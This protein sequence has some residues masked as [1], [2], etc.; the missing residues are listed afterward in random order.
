[1]ENQKELHIPV[2]SVWKN[3]TILKNIFL[4]NSPP[5]IPNETQ[6][7]K[8]E[9]C[10]TQQDFEETLVVGRHP[11]CH[12][13]V[14]HPSISRFHLRIHSKPTSKHLS[15]TDLSSVHGTW[16]S[17]KKIK[18]NVRT[19]MNE[20][21]TLRI[22][23]SSR[24]YKLH[25]IPLSQA[26]D[27]SNPFVPPLDLAAAQEDKEEEII[28]DESPLE[29]QNKE[30]QAVDSTSKDIEFS[31]VCD[32]DELAKV[33]VPH[34][35]EEN[36]IALDE[37][38]QVAQEEMPPDPPT[39]KVNFENVNESLQSQDSMLEGL[40]P[41]FLGENWE[42]IGQ[43]GNYIACPTEEGYPAEVKHEYRDYTGSV[44]EGLDSSFL[45]EN[46]ELLIHD[47]I[48]L[49]PSVIE[50]LAVHMATDLQNAIAGE[51]GGGVVSGMIQN[52]GGRHVDTV[53]EGLDTL[54]LDENLEVLVQKGTPLAPSMI[55]DM[56]VQMETNLN[57]TTIEASIPLVPSVV[58]DL[59]VHTATD[60]HNAM[61]GERECGVVSGMI[62]NDG[63]RH[64]D[65]LSLDILFPDEN[66]EL[67]VQKGTPLATSMIEDMPVKMEPNF[68][69]TTIEEIQSGIE[70][71]TIPNE[72]QI[73]QEK[74]DIQDDV[75]NFWCG[76][77]IPPASLTTE[78]VVLS[79]ENIH[80][81]NEHQ[82][83][84][85]ES[86]PCIP[87]ERKGLENVNV[88]QDSSIKDTNGTKL[89]SFWS[90]NMGVES[91]V[92]SSLSD[93]E[94]LSESEY[95]KSSR[96]SDQSPPLSSIKSAFGSPLIESDQKSASC[97]WLR[98]GKL[99]SAPQILTSRS[100]GKKTRSEQRKVKHEPLCKALFQETDA[101]KDEEEIYTPDKENFT[102]NARRSMKKRTMLRE[103]K[104]SNAG[105]SFFS[106][107]I[108]NSKVDYEDSLSPSS[109]KENNSPGTFLQ[110]E[111]TLH[112][113]VNKPK[114]IQ[115]RER[116][117]ER[118]PFQSLLADSPQRNTSETC[119]PD[120]ILN[121]DKCS[122]Q[123]I[124]EWR[125]LVDTTTLLNKKSRKAL[126]LLEGL[127]G[128][129]LIIPRIVINDLACLKRQTSFFRRNTEVSSALDW[130]E[131][132]MA[133]S[134]WWIHVQ[135]SSEE[136]GPVAPTPPASPCS[137]VSSSS[138]FSNFV[139][140]PELLSPAVEDHVIDYALSLKSKVNEGQ[141]VLLSC[142]VALKIKAMAEGVI[143]ETPE[144]FRESLVNPFSER[145]LW[146][147]SSPRGQ[148][149]SC[150]ED[151][152]L[153]EKFYPSSLKMTPKAMENVKGLK[154]IL[155]HNS[156]YFER[157]TTIH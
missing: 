58:E 79:N 31:V 105:K 134:Q 66:H 44:L 38:A 63:G 40:V 82:C 53:L 12:I 64:V 121:K 14:E 115:L 62:Q 156:Q 78:R 153:R 149:W 39:R 130:I 76:S 140:P 138:I 68:N 41:L 50:D 13:R 135:N 33:Q 32:K 20:D 87:S 54:F 9:I 46:S 52:D 22:G 73:P 101:Q 111:T 91:S 108:G 146:A 102:P 132:C 7:E 69:T 45:D 150:S 118:M 139:N 129:R 18:A 75:W 26:Y 131:D 114:S 117:G 148:T 6:K 103:L 107:V 10:K 98:R 70:S 141:L 110:Q 155:L 37:L 60:L 142:D 124:R 29:L 85:N 24:V 128:T 1:M 90:G 61:V 93:A 154:L 89:W 95:N 49:V 28:I 59:A 81:E 113:S 74:K 2:F 23:G 152:V 21:D 34:Q 11:D 65:T 42:W 5:S 83:Q 109:D 92:C 133:K 15:V 126:Q 119:F 151:I 125:M 122:G 67:L 145:F 147:D 57:T 104:N 137:H 8:S 99:Q 127:K 120:A 77:L 25:W 56:P 35:T 4:I 144:D 36:L 100:A 47:V 30:V 43:D 80:L 97:I 143:C 72:N 136:A 123:K 3:N 17:G 55:E 157:M 84:E 88:D 71:E 16:V 116:R 48:P 94:F 112:A 96:Y 51:R 86:D 106:N 27:V 19:R